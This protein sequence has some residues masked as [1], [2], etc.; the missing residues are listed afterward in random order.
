MAHPP[1]YSF[2]FAAKTVCLS[3]AFRE[4]DTQKTLLARIS[5]P[6]GGARLIGGGEGCGG[7]FCVECWCLETQQKG[8]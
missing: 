6:C 8:D 7:C 1:N 2:V 4:S 3:T 5:L